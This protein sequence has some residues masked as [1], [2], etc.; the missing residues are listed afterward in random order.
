VIEEASSA[1]RRRHEHSRKTVSKASI[2][3][4]RRNLEDLLEFL[5]E[6]DLGWQ[7]VLAGDVWTRRNGT[8]RYASDNDQILLGKAVSIT[9]KYVSQI[10]C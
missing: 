1:S 7:T 3:I 9:D 5:Y 8:I 2:A 4:A 10:T 6:L